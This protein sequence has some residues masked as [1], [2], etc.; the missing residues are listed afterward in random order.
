MKEG[1][2][3]VIVE[4]PGKIK[5]IQDALGKENFIVKASM[6]HIRDLDESGLSIDV[7]NG[8][9]PEYVIPADK[10]KVVAD[11]KKEAKSA[12]A[13]WL[14]SDADREGEAISWHLFETLGLK[15][16]NT[17]RI[18]FQEI[19]DTAIQ[20]AIKNPRE[21]DMNLVNAQQA[22]RVLDRLVGFELSPVLWRKIQPKLSAGRVQS[23]ALRLIVDREREI[24]SFNNEAYYKVE[25]VFHPEGTPENTLVKATLDTRFPDLESAQ[26][27]LEKCIGANFSICDIN[28]KEGNR[29]PAAP[30]TTS[31]LQQEAARKLRMSV[32]QTMSIAQ[33]LYESGYITYMRTDSTNLSALA[34]G[35]AKKFICDN[36]GEEYS[37]PR[38]YKTKSKGAQEAHEAIRP[39]FI[40]N[41]SIE[42]TPQ[43]KKLYELIWKRTVASQMADARVLRTDIKVASDK[44]S[45][46]FNVQATQVLFDGFLK[47]YIESTDDPQ[48]DDE[49][50]ILPE[51]HIGDVMTQQE[52]KA[53]CKFTAAPSRYTDASLIKKLE[54][55]E[56]GRPSTYSPTITTLTKARGYVV[57]GDKPG[58]KHTVTNLTL[59]NGKIKSSTK[60]ET[61]GAEKGRLLPQDIGM[62]VTDFLVKNFESI[63]DYGFTAN[64]EKD[65]DQIAEGELVWNK[66]I[67]DFYG[68]FHTK[69][70][71][72]LSN[73]EYSN[74]SREIGVDPKDGQ[75]LV[76][77]FGQYGPYVQKGEGES[78]QYA[79][80][81][82]GQLIESITLEEALRLFELPRTIGQHKGIDIICTKGRFGPYIKYG[83][84]NISLPRGTDPLKVDLDTCIGLI[85]DSLNKKTGGII[86]EFK[87]SDIQV[88]DGNYGPYIKHAGSNYKIPKGTDPA[89]LTEDKCKEII[90][91]S[92]P[93]GRKKRRK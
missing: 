19:T 67:S 75:L 33:R 90:E 71:E 49:A 51:M 82:P 39:T 56:I 24:L 59:K 45:E 15:K 60:S 1:K 40:G 7:K 26:S 64:V 89:M 34:L 16:E 20:N 11:L 84:K 92:E 61:V 54:E 55:L 37:K 87:D 27:F 43:E 35:T 8:F 69:V 21:I 86:A 38:Q 85:E 72:T 14:A 48:Q 12:S 68:S 2:N 31:T 22:R 23:V 5:K 46:R 3:L 93:T 17:K 74:V 36:F 29:F 73:R 28:E 77:R 65:F 58:E 66:V 32:S 88:I 47:L 62:I 57:K 42:G 91:N 13:V 41:T 25:A 53:E 78:K 81:A 18:V 80:L 52:I 6:G 70:E 63:L 76:A 83:D 30:F 10:K 4:S 50:V 9:K 79:S 44:S